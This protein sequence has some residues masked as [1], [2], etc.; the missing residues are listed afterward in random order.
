MV[1]ESVRRHGNVG[2][3]PVRGVIGDG[4]GAGCE[5]AAFARHVAAAKAGG[6][7]ALLI[8]VDSPGGNIAAGIKMTYTLS[9]SGLPTIAYV[10][11]RADSM[12]SAVALSADFVVI[13]PRG[14]FR[15]H[16]PSGASPSALAAYRDR[17]LA[18]YTARTF[19]SR[20]LA[21]GY[22]S[23]DVR[24]DAQSAYVEGLADEI[25][26]ASRAEDLARAA[27]TTAGLW[28]APLRDAWRRHVLR[29]RAAAAAGVARYRA[30]P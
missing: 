2:H 24:I 22:M 25:G 9:C 10:R 12:A 21:D 4:P 14:S 15:L 3:V 5:P 19:M 6:A 26:D 7:R 20:A 18:V 29:E 16:D 28:S 8:T 23:G 13:D 27:T 30:G 1:A 11:G 17:L